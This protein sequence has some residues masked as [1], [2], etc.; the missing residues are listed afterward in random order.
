MGLFE[1]SATCARAEPPPRAVPMAAAMASPTGV[2]TNCLPTINRRL[3]PG[4]SRDST[5]CSRRAKDSAFHLTT[6]VFLFATAGRCRRGGADPASDEPPA[7]LSGA[8]ERAG[9]VQGFF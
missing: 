4:L 5:T 2:R 7:L 6:L 1:S 3:S 9:L 8:A